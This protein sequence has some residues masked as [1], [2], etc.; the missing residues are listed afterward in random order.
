MTIMDLIRR[1]DADERDT[2]YLKKAFLDFAHLR[3]K[4]EKFN[5]ESGD[6][7]EYMNLLSERKAKASS[8]EGFITGLVTMDYI[9][10]EEYGCLLERIV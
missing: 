1:L 9:S 6:F 4:I 10:L 3:E 7:Q 8:L 2:S 5:F